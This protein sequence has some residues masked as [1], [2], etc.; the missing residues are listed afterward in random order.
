MKV[1][2]ASASERRQELLGRLI[3]K[4]EVMVSDFDE[5][6]VKFEGSIDRYVKNVALGKAIDI[7]D[8][9]IDDAIIISADTI[10]TLEDKLL[11]KPKDEEDAFKMIKSLQGRSHFVYSGIVVINTAKN[12]IKQESLKTEVTFSQISDKEI[13]EY[14]KTGEPLD[15]AGAYGIQ[16]LG[17][18]FVKEIRGCYYN[19][20]GLSLNKLKSMLDEVQ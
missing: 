16:G 15:K 11:G 20:V 10:V 9:I 13:I 5:S 6:K 4:F 8:K 3:K 19:V 18:V 14:I 12:I 2:L 17:G 7:K 1:V